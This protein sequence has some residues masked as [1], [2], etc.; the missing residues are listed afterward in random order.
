[1]PCAV[2][3]AWRAR[4]RDDAG[5]EQAV[6]AGGAPGRA[7]LPPA[8]GPDGPH[9][10]GAF[11]RCAEPRRNIPR[12][13]GR[14]GAIRRELDHGPEP[15]ALRGPDPVAGTAFA[16]VEAGTRPTDRTVDSSSLESIVADV[17]RLAGARSNDE[18]GIAL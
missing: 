1:M 17:I 15:A 8:A 2:A 6:A 18:K 9:D 12:P 16:A 14:A 4:D 5:I 11:R 3:G 7:P 13:G 10:V